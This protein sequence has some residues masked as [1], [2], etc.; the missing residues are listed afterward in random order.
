MKYERKIRL[1]STS[2][3]CIFTVLI[4]APLEMYLTNINE[5][6]FSLSQFWFVPVLFGV[7]GFVVLSILGWRMPH[8][9]D[10]IYITVIF[11]LGTMMYVQAN[12]L[13]IDVGVLNG[14]NV[15]WHDY[16]LKFFLN[17][18]VW[19]LV[20]SFWLFFLSKKCQLCNQI[21]RYC[22]VCL[23]L[24]QAIA[25]VVLLFT[26]KSD[27]EKNQVSQYV[28][29]KDIYT[30]SEEENIVVFLADMFDDRYFKELLVAEPE[31]A[32]EF[33]G[34]TQYTNSTGN[35][36]TTIYSIAT[37][38]TGQYLRNTE[39]SYYDERDSLYEKCET[40]NE[41]IDNGYKVDIYTSEFM[42]P[43][44]L[45]EI[46]D[47]YI[48]GGEKVSSY[49]K[50]SQY[51]YRLVATKYMPDFFKQHI[52][53]VG[54]E[55]DTV[56]SR[57]GEADAHSFDNV[58]FYENLLKDGI[59][60]QQDNKYFKFIHLD[61]VH[62]PYLI[63]E[64]A[65][66]V[67]ESETSDL[68]CARGVVKILSE[69]MAEMKQVGVYDNTS[70]IIMADHG[71]Y[72]DGVLTNPVLLV[73]PKNSKGALV[74]SSAPVSQHDFHASIMTLAGLN[75]SKQYGK[76]YMDIQE[77]EK[78]ERL[79]YQYYLQEPTDDGR[80]RLIEYEVDPE[81]NARTNFHLTGTEYTVDGVKINHFEKCRLCQSGYV[82]TSD[83]DERIVHK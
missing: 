34:F 45:R 57:S 14:G 54:N 18:I 62:Y 1:F 5:F 11:A 39:E 16:R 61:G 59:S 2:L 20:I 68:E 33:E 25:L 77:D 66:S 63:N 42:I 80:H 65:E 64:N 73:K 30:L 49:F 51:M 27:G 21:I 32:K 8:P 55:F 24:V 40:Y 41:L 29:S 60:V 12:F 35:Y 69:Y 38:L 44:K 72:W 46:T 50:L 58:S 37:L 9:I 75:D 23:I 10:D 7:T 70:I 78:R 22:S 48:M 26:C 56:C 15:E 3:F 31:L 79:F 43:R 47:N 6:W 52:W 74:A 71:Y 67:D 36:S 83:H 4:Y 13:N 82:E 19:L 81:G 17:F 76:S 28:S 53:L